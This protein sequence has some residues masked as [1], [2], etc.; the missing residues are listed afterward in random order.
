M[1]LL[2]VILGLSIVTNMSYGQGMFDKLK[3]EAEKGE[4]SLANVDPATVTKVSDQ[5]MAKLGPALKLS[6][7]QKASVSTS[8]N[9]YLKNKAATQPL[10]VT[11]KPAYTAKTKENKTDLMGKMKS[12]LTKD[13]MS[14][15]LKMKPKTGDKSNPLSAIF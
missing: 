5:I 4:S 13:Q 2:F 11:D 7:A 10:A 14:K 9:G 12:Y 8:I 1:K 15:F 6:D 3:S